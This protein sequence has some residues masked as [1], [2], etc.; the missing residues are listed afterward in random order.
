MKLLLQ[1]LH[2]DVAAAGLGRG[3]VATSQRKLYRNEMRAETQNKIKVESTF[4]V[5]YGRIV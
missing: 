2:R 3:D 1:A 4:D 5:S